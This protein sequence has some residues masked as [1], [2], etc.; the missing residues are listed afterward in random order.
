MYLQSLFIDA[1]FDSIRVFPQ[2]LQETNQMLN[3]VSQ[4]MHFLGHAYHS[5]SDIIILPSNP[6]PRPL[7][8]RPILI[9]PPAM[10]PAGIPIQLEVR[11]PRFFVQILVTFLCSFR[12]LFRDSLQLYKS[13]FRGPVF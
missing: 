4:V 6:P 11:T 9:Q 1:R 13:L 3:R 2:E 12:V 8:C 5:L 7:L 10:V